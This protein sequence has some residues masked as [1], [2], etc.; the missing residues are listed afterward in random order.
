MV[1]DQQLHLP[2][3]EFAV[4]KQHSEIKKYDEKHTFSLLFKLSTFNGILKC[5]K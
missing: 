4:L 5:G 2:S 1:M 3:V